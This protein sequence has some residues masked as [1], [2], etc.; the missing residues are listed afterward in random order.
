M[1][2][3]LLLSEGDGNIKKSKDVNKPQKNISSVCNE[4]G[5][6]DIA[7]LY[8]KAI[9]TYHNKTDIKNP[10][11]RRKKSLEEFEEYINLIY[12]L[13]PEY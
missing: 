11:K 5:F 3:R 6:N 8:K 9:S 2:R 7:D 4:E 13:E 1:N 12:N 10:E